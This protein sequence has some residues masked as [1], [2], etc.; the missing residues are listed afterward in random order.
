[1]SHCYSHGVNA[2]KVDRLTEIAP[3]DFTMMTIQEIIRSSG[4]PWRDILEKKQD[5]DRILQ[6]VSEAS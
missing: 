4:D 3:T 5:L 2:C 6:R 1:V